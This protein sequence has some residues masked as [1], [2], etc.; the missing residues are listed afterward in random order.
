[1]KYKFEVFV[2]FEKWKIF[3][4]NQTGKRLKSL[5]TDNGLEFCNKEFSNLCEKFGIKRH[6]TNPY[7][8]QQ[9]GVAERMNR[10]LLD[11]VRCM[12]ISSGLPKSFWGETI[13][14]AA[15]LLNLSPSV[16]LSGKTPEFMWT[17]RKSDIS[18]LRVFGCSAFV[19]QNLDK[20]EPRSV[21]CAFIGYPEGIKG[22]RLWVHSQPGFKVLIS[23][24]VTFNENEF[25]CLD[26]TQYREK[27]PTFSKVEDHLGD[28]QE[29]EE[30]NENLV[31][32]TTDNEARIT[33]NSLNDYQL[34]RDR[35]RRETRIP[36][37]LRD[38]QTALNTELCEPTNVEKAMKSDKWLSAMEEEMRSLKLNETWTLVPRPKTSSVVDCKWIFKIK[39]EN[40][41]KY[42]ARLVAKGFTQKEGIDYNEIFSPVVKYTTVRII[43][44]LTAH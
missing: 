33:E 17:G 18:Y 31:E 41:I 42:K 44:A 35:V 36:L 2:K 24:D 40:P 25:P 26:K 37:R 7:I 34:A 22:Y 12:F 11:K 43:L 16:P 13:L 4:E 23:R 1:M 21:K 14:T 3:V 9:N 39:Q 15:H 38:Y 19:H 6:R 29:G 8:P 20:L 30:N 27:E 10:T 28:N 5:R 32:S